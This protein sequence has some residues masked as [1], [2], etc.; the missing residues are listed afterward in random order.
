MSGFDIQQKVKNGLSKAVTATGGS[1][2]IVELR[3]VSI[4]SDPINGDVETESWVTLVD[5]I[6]KSYDKKLI[7]GD[8]ITTADRELVSNSDVDITQNAIVRSDGIK[9][10]VQSVDKAS[11]AG[12]TLVYKSHCRRQ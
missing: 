1:G 3:V 12:V 4:V 5:A 10:I 8:M 2:V 11:P 9:Y 6:F 7:D